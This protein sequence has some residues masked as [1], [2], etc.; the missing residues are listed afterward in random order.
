M[1][2]YYFFLGYA[3][4]WAPFY[5]PTEALNKVPKYPNEDKAG[6]MNGTIQPYSTTLS[7]S[8]SYQSTS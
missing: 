5:N 4:L 2:I 7:Y 6:A 8:T 3:N 1:Q